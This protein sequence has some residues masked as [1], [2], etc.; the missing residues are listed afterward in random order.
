[1]KWCY[2]RK[3]ADILKQDDL[4]VIIHQCNCFHTMG[5]GVAKAI[6][7][8]YPEAYEADLKTGYGSREKL[9]DFSYYQ[10]EKL[11]INLYSQHY[12]GLGVFTDYSALYIGL[13]KVRDFLITFNKPLKIGIPFMIGCG[14]AGGKI[15]LVDKTIESVFYGYDDLEIIYCN[16]ENKN[17]E[18]YL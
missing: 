16:L 6:K 15:P 12:F 10:G 8:K 3:N 7:A 4:D 17:L 1:M 13:E 14:L 11:I 2:Y 18:D 5:A 9:G